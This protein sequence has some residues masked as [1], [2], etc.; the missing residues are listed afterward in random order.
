LLGPHGAIHHN[1]ETNSPAKDG[2]DV[3]TA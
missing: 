2:L 3:E 1:D